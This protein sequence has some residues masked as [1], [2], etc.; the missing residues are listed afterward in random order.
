MD[1]NSILNNNQSIERKD[2]TYNTNKENIT[3]MGEQSKSDG[4]NINPSSENKQVVQVPQNQ[5]E[6]H[7]AYRSVVQQQQMA[8][9]APQQQASQQQVPYGQ[10]QV[11]QHAAYR[12]MVQQQVAPQ[13]QVPQQQ[14]SQ[15]QVPYG[16]N[17][18]VQQ[19]PYR[20]MAQQ[21]AAPQQ[22]MAQQASQQQMPYGQNQMVQ[23]NPYRPMAQQQ[24]APQQQ[25]AQQ[26]PYGQ[27]QMMQQN[28]Y[29]QMPQ[30]QGYYTQNG[31]GYNQ[32]LGT[33]DYYNTQFYPNKP[34]S[35]W[36]IPVIIT[37][38]IAA[39]IFIFVFIAANVIE[40]TDNN[41][42]VDADS[43]EERLEREY[44]IVINVG[45]EADCNESGYS[46]DKLTNERTIKNALVHIETILDR[47]PEGFMEDVMSGYSDAYD[48][49]HDRYLEINITGSMTDESDG[50][51]VLGLTSYS[52]EKTVIRMD[53]TVFSWDEY[54]LTFAHELFHVIDFEMDQFEYT[55]DLDRWEECNPSGYRY[56][57]DAGQ[58]SRYVDSSDVSDCYFVSYY[59]KEDIY[60]D[61]AE[62]FSYLL[63]TASDDELPKVFDSEHIEDKVELLVS[64]IE[65]HFNT[66]GESAYWNRWY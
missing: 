23:Q 57:Y 16:Q 46:I 39:C 26:M 21:Q 60:E 14:A 63:A 27:G 13:Q 32:P 7:A 59:S 33:G 65:S 38:I 1:N 2:D 54:E 47:L 4:V 66:V 19:N 9:Q 44:G 62:I 37:S 15:Q 51:T 29:G 55:V 34:K 6:Q 58:S 28:P 20:P 31:W 36:K 61:R 17:Q 18:M 11:A 41:A 43:I 5:I 50:R 10:N 52:E 53:A 45:K 40:K 42:S 56:S 8:Q 22:Q 49:G 12:P 25:M 35:I 3:V 24:V 48:L 64:E 30:Q